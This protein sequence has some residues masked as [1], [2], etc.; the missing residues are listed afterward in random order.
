MIVEPA[1]STMPRE[2]VLMSFT[3]IILV[4][5][6]LA[7]VRSYRCGTCPDEV[8]KWAWTFPVFRTKTTESD[9]GLCTLTSQ[10]L[11]VNTFMTLVVALL[12]NTFIG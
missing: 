10:M 4:L 5:S 1:A 3:C 12:V 7:G 2:S 11:V 6:A 8:R 9:N